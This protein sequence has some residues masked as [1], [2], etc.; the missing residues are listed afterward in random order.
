MYTLDTLIGN[1]AWVS[2]YREVAKNTLY[3]SEGFTHINPDGKVWRNDIGA[4]TIVVDDDK[5]RVE[6]GFRP[7]S[8]LLYRATGLD[9]REYPTYTIGDA[10][11]II[12][13]FPK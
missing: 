7:R 12:L 8:G 11:E 6:T 4:I 9:I 1:I 5:G 3:Y 2:E 10:I 13:N